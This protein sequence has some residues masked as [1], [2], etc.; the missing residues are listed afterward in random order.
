MFD[1]TRTT[2]LGSVRVDLGRDP[3]EHWSQ[4]FFGFQSSR[5]HA[6]CSTLHVT[7]LLQAD[8]ALVNGYVKSTHW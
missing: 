1:W 6:A 5:I 7:A 8:R 2:Y 4:A 3:L